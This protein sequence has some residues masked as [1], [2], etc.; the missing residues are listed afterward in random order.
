MP[1]GQHP[2]ASHITVAGDYFRAMKI[3]VRHGRVFTRADTKDAPRVI[4]VNEAFARKFFADR[5]PIGQHVMI[6][7]PEDKAPPREVIGVVGNTRHESLQKE[8]QPEM[9]L[10][11]SQSP[12]RGVEAVFRVSS[13]S[14]SGLDA[15]VRR[16]VQEVDKTL[17]VPKLEPVTSL[18]STQ[19]AQPRFNMMLLATF[20]GVAMALAAIGIYGVIAYNVA[21]RTREIGI[22]MALGAQR[23]QM[24]GM[25]LRQ[26]LTLVA[27][28]LTIGL[29]AS[30][31][32]TRLLS[33]LL[34]GIGATDWSTYT[35]V[36]LLLAAAAFLASYIPARRAMRVDP[37]VAIR[38]E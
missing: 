2:E 28:G 3:P 21:Q 38:Y 30:L 37:M 18:V 9:Y 4:M 20:A 11:V 6:D 27:L 1:R 26:S 17:F 32:G 16:A 15:A 22:R 24:L 5:D 8:P 33:S 29:V 10:P 12:T 25:V 34:F 35:L 13:T 31:A 7:G 23:K 19:L 36:V 14:L